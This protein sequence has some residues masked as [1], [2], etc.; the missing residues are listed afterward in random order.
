MKNSYQVAKYK[1]PKGL[2]SNDE[3]KNTWNPSETPLENLKRMGLQIRANDDVK[4]PSGKNV[5]NTVKGDASKAIELF[6]IPADGRIK[7]R[8]KA[9]VML[10]ISIDD[11]EYIVKLLKKHKVRARAVGG[12]GE[13]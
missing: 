11:Q 8:T 4:K 5:V 6:D 12:R 7:G 10:P 13:K 2:F 9:D 1:N 3:V